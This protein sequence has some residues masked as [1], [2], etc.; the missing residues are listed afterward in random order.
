MK[1]ENINE[2]RDRVS[3]N[4]IE[5]LHL[6]KGDLLILKIGYRPTKDKF[7]E[8]L[9][10]INDKMDRAGIR[11]EILVLMNDENLSVISG[12]KAKYM[13]RFTPLK[14]EDDKEADIAEWA[15]KVKA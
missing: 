14:L 7:K 12:S 3:I 8:V 10:R 11:T 9:K 5:H 6:E 1:W 13:K 15:E 4:G 2:S